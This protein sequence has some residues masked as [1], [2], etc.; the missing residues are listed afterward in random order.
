MFRIVPLP[1]KGRVKK[2]AHV[3]GMAGMSPCPPGCTF[4]TIIIIN[5]IRYCVYMC[6]SGMLLIQC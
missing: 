2:H 1:F 5:E 3:P 4:N 6:E